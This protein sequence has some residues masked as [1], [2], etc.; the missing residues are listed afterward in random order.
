MTISWAEF[1]GYFLSA[2]A[3]GLTKTSF[4]T[5]VGIVLT[6]LLSIYL[7]PRFVLAILAPMMIIGDFAVAYF[8]WKKWDGK[9]F[10]VMF[11]AMAAGVVLGALLVSRLSNQQARIAIGVLVLIFAGY[12]LLAMIRKSEL[13]YVPP[14]KGVGSVM[15]FFSGFSSSAAHAGG[16]ISVPYFVASGLSKEGIV[17]TNFA[18]FAVSN[19]VKL[20]SYVSVGMVDWEIILWTLYMLPVAVL[21]GFAGRWVNRTVSRETFN[22]VALILALGGAIKLFF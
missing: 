22:R 5:G 9:F 21:G 16:A 18:L 1:S 13:I 15:G 4:G 10:W 19:W 17:A 3:V 2:F 14:K 8:L 12:Q 6:P 20:G 7:P 11:P